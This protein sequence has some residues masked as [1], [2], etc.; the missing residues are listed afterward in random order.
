[1]DEVP[2]LTSRTN[3][4]RYNKLNGADQPMTPMTHVPPEKACVSM[5]KLRLFIELNNFPFEIVPISEN[6]I[7]IRCT[8]EEPPVGT[9]RAF[10]KAIFETVGFQRKIDRWGSNQLVWCGHETEHMYTSFDFDTIKTKYE[11]YK[12]DYEDAEEWS[13]SWLKVPRKLTF[14]SAAKLEF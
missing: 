14:K 4:Y 10:Y 2:F 8:C 5:D 12:N 13:D 9:K 3:V 11:T 7:C 6:R 1:M